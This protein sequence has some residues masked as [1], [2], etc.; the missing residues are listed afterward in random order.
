MVSFLAAVV[1]GP[2]C[3]YFLGGVPLVVLL[4]VFFP[5][6]F[7][8]VMSFLDGVGGLLWL[9]SLGGHTVFPSRF[10]LFYYVFLAGCNPDDAGA[11]EIPG[12]AQS[13][14]T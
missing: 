10:D 5:W 7:S 11:E 4:D 3:W 8:M 9:C 1:G 12:R 13:P 2:P 14:T 6:W